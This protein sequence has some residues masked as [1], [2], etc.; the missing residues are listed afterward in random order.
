MAV[1]CACGVAWLSRILSCINGVPRSF[2][3]DVTFVC[4]L[5]SLLLGLFAAFEVFLCLKESHTISWSWPVV[6]V[7]AFSLYVLAMLCCYGALLR[8][9]TS[10]PR[11]PTPPSDPSGVGYSEARTELQ[12]LRMMAAR[13]NHDDDDVTAIAE[14]YGEDPAGGG[15]QSVLIN[16]DDDLPDLSDGLSELAYDDERAAW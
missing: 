13:R 3:R 7:P 14:R 10:Y 1:M 2:V 8:G 4:P 15:G 5:A 11:P 16:S 12:S 6:F 9:H